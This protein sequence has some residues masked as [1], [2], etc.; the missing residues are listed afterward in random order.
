MKDILQDVKKYI[1]MSMKYF[2]DG[3]VKWYHST[4][5]S[6]KDVEVR[7]QT[8]HADTEIFLIVPITSDIK[9]VV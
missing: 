7:L 9:V 5:L 8:K 4:P 1:I 2:K 6:K 3:E